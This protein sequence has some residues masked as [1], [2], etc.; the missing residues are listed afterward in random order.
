MCRNSRFAF[1]ALF[2]LCFVACSAQT[3]SPSELIRYLTF[4]SDRPEKLQVEMGLDPCSDFGDRK[5]AVAL[6]QIGLAA[7]SDIEKELDA[8]EQPGYEGLGSGWLELAYARIKGPAAYERLRKMERD[9]KIGSDRLFGDD[10]R[11]RTLDGAIALSLG[12]TSFVSAPKGT[13]ENERQCISDSGVSSLSHGPCPSGARAEP[14]ANFNCHRGMDPRDA[15]NRLIRTFERNDDFTFQVGLGPDAKVAFNSLLT[16][17]TW[18]QLRTAILKSD[19]PGDFAVGYRFEGSGR[20]SEPDETLDEH[21]D[22]SPNAESPAIE[23]HF[24]TRSGADCGTYQVQ[25]LLA[26]ADG[27]THFWTPYLVNNSDLAGLLQNIASCA[28][29]D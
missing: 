2:L 12:I 15:L 11:R 8:I 29:R 9:P 26:P 3:Q 10:L 23:T 19:S 5:A 18:S 6:A 7:L 1:P 22:N 28:V 25:F 14:I 20:W 16:G 17:K 13:V 24:Q 4:Q 27:R 21:R